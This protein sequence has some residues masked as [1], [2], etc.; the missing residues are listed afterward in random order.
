MSRPAT[1][2]DARKLNFWIGHDTV[3]QL[4]AL[5]RMHIGLPSRAE[6]LRK[7]IEKEW[8]RLAPTPQPK[9]RNEPPTVCEFLRRHG[10]IRDEHGELRAMAAHRERPGLVNN[11]R[12]IS[13]DHARE[14]LVQAG[15]LRESGP[16]EPAIT[17][18]AD[19]L[20]LIRDE[21]SGIRHQPD[22][23]F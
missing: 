9:R 17:T 2:A 13:L 10:G 16:H 6:I 23:P 4:D 14:L 1:L 15:Y 22:V 21:L 7:L 8:A 5:R 11:V 12:G 19:V 20:D 18:V 3:E